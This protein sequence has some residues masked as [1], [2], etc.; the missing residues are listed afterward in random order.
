[1]PV[2]EAELRGPF[3]GVIRLRP[4][5]R[6]RIGRHPHNDLVIARDTVSRF[7]AELDWP[8]KAARP[9][10]R[11][12]ASSNGTRVDGLFLERDERRALD[13]G[14]VIQVGGIALRLTIRGETPPAP[15]DPDTVRMLASSSDLLVAFE[16]APAPIT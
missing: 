5:Q 8:P 1:M 6:V 9:R 15:L 4:G 13:P 11:D 16:P 14:A 12:L 10:A 3:A 2:L 7:H